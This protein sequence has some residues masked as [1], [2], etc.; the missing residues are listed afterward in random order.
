MTNVV[1]DVWTRARARSGQLDHLGKALGRYFSDSSDR[2]AASVSYYGFLCVFPLLLLVASVVGFV[3]GSDLERQ[4]QLLGHLGDF[5]PDTLARPLV[6]LV[7]ERAGITGAV[8]LVGLIIAGLGW[9]DALRESLRAVW[10]QDPHRG[11]ILRKKLTDLVILTG[12]GAT[13]LASVAVSAFATT[14][15]GQG[16][17]LLGVSADRPVAATGLRTVALVVALLTN[18]AVLSYLMLWLPRSTEPLRRVLRAAVVGAV[19]LEIAK[20]IGFYYFG[21]VLGK[22]T[23][24]YGAGLAVAFGLLLWI[25]VA[26]RPVLF[27]AAW[28]VTAPYRADV[29]PSGTSPEPPPA[30]AAPDAPE[31]RAT[32]DQG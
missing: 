16:L 12:L 1:A 26:A 17:G 27:T 8:G 29:R 32:A 23:S 22:G 30:D 11:R 10:H 24:L 21:V 25:N 14:L 3:V 4:R 28:A 9:V 7:T 18:T 13:I 2:L 19:A 20:Y 15:A 5:A 31:E 6:T